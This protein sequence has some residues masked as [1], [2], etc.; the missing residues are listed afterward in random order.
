MTKKNKRVTGIGGVFFKCKEPDKMR[1]WYNENLGL[2]TNEYGSLFEFRK[3]DDPDKIGY[4]QWSTFS[5]NTKYFEPSKKEFMINY[6]VENLVELLEDLKKKGV[7]IVGE[8]EEY[9][10]GKFA[11]ILDPEGNKLELWEPV[12]KVF[13]DLYDGKTT[14]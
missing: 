8:M 14:H 9:E 5:H 11:W 2:V 10:Y 4:L 7:E 3:T 1:S 12:D 13:T 6:R